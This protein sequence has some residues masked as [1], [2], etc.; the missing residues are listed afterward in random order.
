TNLLDVGVEAEGRAGALGFLAQQVR[1]LATVADRVVL[2]VDACMQ[3]RLRVQS[4]LDGAAR[5]GVEDDRRDTE[6]GERVHAG[7]GDGELARAAQEDEEALR[8][9]ELEM[10]T[11]RQLLQALAAEV[12]EAVHAS[13]VGTVDL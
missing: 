1:G 9:L 7:L 2:R 13:P 5:R 3:R 4:G 12:G 10:Q 11:R 8:P 6:L